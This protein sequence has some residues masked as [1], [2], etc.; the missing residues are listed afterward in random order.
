[1]RSYSYFYRSIGDKNAGNG[2][3]LLVVVLVVMMVVVYGGD[4]IDANGDNVGD[5]R[6]SKKIVEE[7]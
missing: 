1:M 7:A 3:D 4:V 5:I 6:L 2:V